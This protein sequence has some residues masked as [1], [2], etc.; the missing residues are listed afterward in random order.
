M[1]KRH[2]G[3]HFLFDTSILRR[4]VET[5]G[6]NQTDTVVEVGPGHG[7]LT[8]LLLKRVNR[9]IAIELDSYFAET[10]REKFKDYKNLEIHEGDALRYPYETLETFKVVSNIPY[11]ITTPLIFR[12][13]KAKDKL[14]SMTL[15]IQKE[16][17]E[18]IVASP[19]GKSYG[20]LSIAVQYHGLAK[21]AFVIP[22]GAFRPV[23]KVDSAVL[24]IDI[25]KSPTVDVQ[26]EDLFFKVVRG[27]FGQ[28]RK[29]LLNSLKPLFP[30]VKRSLEAVQIEGS[31]R[32]ETLSIEEFALLS[33]AIKSHLSGL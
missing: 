11:Y 6:V 3:Q 32:A 8:E 5:S 16:V 30:D 13:L 21:I 27:A 24:R 4:I 33:K 25:D 12:L 17:A 2:L 9:L 31:R 22:K 28:R 26:D 1:A 10:L 23:P 29:T 20:V 18:R 15:T 14:L 7:R 19:G